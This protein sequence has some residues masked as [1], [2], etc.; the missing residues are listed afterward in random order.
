MKQE[1]NGNLDEL[2]C[3]T[4]FRLNRS[5]KDAELLANY[6]PKYEPLKHLAEAYTK[7]CLAERYKLKLH[8]F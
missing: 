5:L 1:P 2:S 4:I 7:P 3:F 8:M 6:L